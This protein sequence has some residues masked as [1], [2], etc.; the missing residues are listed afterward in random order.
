MEDHLLNQTD[1]DMVDLLD[2]NIGPFGYTHENQNDNF[3]P[4]L[5]DILQK[6][7]ET[8]VFATPVYWCAMSGILKDFFDRISDL[9]KIRKD[10]GRQLRSRSM[11]LIIC[12]SNDE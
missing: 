8:L 5:E 9:L 12:S 10:L 1:W 6:D 3:I 7:Y 11:G 2:Y 4:L